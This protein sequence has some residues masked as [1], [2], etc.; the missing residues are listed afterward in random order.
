MTP[1][2]P[3]SPWPLPR[4][5]ATVALLLIAGC[6]W[7]FPV[8][9]GS[10]TGSSAESGASEETG[11]TGESGATEETAEPIDG[12]G[13]GYPADEDC[14]DSDPSSFPS[15]EVY[16]DSL[17]QDCDG[18]ADQLDAILPSLAREQ[19]LGAAVE[20]VDAT[21]D[22]VADLWFSIAG[23]GPDQ[24]IYLLNGPLTDH[25]GIPPAPTWEPYAEDSRSGL[26]L[27]AKGDLDGDGQDDLAISAPNAE[28]YRGAVLIV[29]GPGAEG[30]SLADVEDRF[31]GS[32]ARSN[33]GDA[34]ASAGDPDDD[35]YDDLLVGATDVDVTE[36]SE[37]AVYL[38]GGPLLDE[39]DEDDAVA[40]V[41]GGVAWQDLGSS[42]AHL[43]DADGDGIG[44]ILVGGP[45]SGSNAPTDVAAIGLGPLSGT[46]TVADLDA[47]LRADGS[48]DAGDAV[49]GADMNGDGYADA[50]VGASARTDDY[51]ESTG[52]VYVSFGPPTSGFLD[53]A[54]LVAPTN[55]RAV[56]LGQELEVAD[57]D[58]DGFMDLLM[59]SPSGWITDLDL[60]G[61][62]ILLFGP[63][64]GTVEVG[65]GGA[66]VVFG[67]QDNDH[68][69][70]S[71][72]IG[73]LNDDGA[74]DLVFGMPD[75]G[76]EGR[77]GGAIGFSWGD[78]W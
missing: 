4:R 28:R 35:G 15:T 74:H 1:R 37:G 31:L 20:I 3:P 12:D 63:E 8:D 17:D 41:L 49:A 10:D 65:P 40:T 43:G 58:Q 26:D 11:T 13:D 72:A 70:G 78:A 6:E 25:F 33:V 7:S 69:G 53:D 73:D 18:E 46:M 52:T 36:S 62:A 2:H 55:S 44:D 30:G 27:D 34:I 54:D 23:Y 67:G 64:T 29:Y 61:I 76:T 39:V 48:S 24:G 50:I 14:D 68:L 57:V 56:Y 45:S 32:S 16:G 77:R 22:G 47:T 19:E 38:L 51:D 71:L 5:A 42:V 21:G 60:D 9:T 75:A 59:G 66:G